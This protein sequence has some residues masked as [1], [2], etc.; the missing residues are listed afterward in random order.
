MPGM[1]VLV[2]YASI[3]L[4]VPAMMKFVV[5]GISTRALL[6]KETMSMLSELV[7]KKSR[8]CTTAGGR[9]V[10]PPPGCSME[11]E[12]SSTTSIRRGLRVACAEDETFR[13]ASPVGP[14]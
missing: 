2:S 8:N 12:R 11:A 7:S 5:S 13:S 6:P 9:P 3:R 14:E 1:V 10:A 4:F